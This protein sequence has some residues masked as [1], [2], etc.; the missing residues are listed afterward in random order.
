MSRLP[1]ILILAFALSLSVQSDLVSSFIPVVHAATSPKAIV[2]IDNPLDRSTNS[3]I[4]LS[5]QQTQ[6]KMEVN[7]TNGP[8]IN[9]FQVVLKYNYN[10]LHAASLDD[11][12]GLL[13]IAAETAGQSVTKALD[14]LD[15]APPP[16]G[17]N[18]GANDG[19]GVISYSAV[20]PVLTPAPSTGQLFSVTFNAQNTTSFSQIQVSQAYLAN[21]TYAQISVGKIDGYYS[22]MTCPVGANPPSTVACT[23]PLVSFTVSPQIPVKNGFT[24]FNGSSTVPS[25]GGKITDY[26]WSWVPDGGTRGSIDTHLSSTAEVSYKVAGTF[27]VTLTVTDSNGL[28]ASATHEIVIID[29]TVDIGISAVTL[30]PSNQN[31]IPGTLISIYAK[32]RNSGFTPQNVTLLIR[33]QGLILNKTSERNLG[34]QS[35]ISLTAKW[36]TTGLPPK[37]YR[38]EAFAPELTNST[39]GAV[40]ESDYVNGVDTNN[41]AY[42][43]VQ[44]VAPFPGGLL[45]LFPSFGLGIVVLGGAGYTVSRL[46]RRKLHDETL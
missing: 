17:G 14:C 38:V 4:D 35:E 39:S 15:D 19:P 13:T 33:I 30:S 18:C 8:P 36:D 43:W 2:G 16:G 46:R 12:N 27:S 21:G 22:S 7:I 24:V 45:G 37:M 31:V 5:H 6:F 41:I 42:Q 20:A 9:S 26:S 25:A 3:F 23:P 40:I 11:T 34:G 44:L 1:V 28:R 10:V 29:S 32:L